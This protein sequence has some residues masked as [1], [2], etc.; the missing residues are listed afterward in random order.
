MRY[1]YVGRDA[2]I[3]AAIQ[4][5]SPPVSAAVL[6]RECLAVRGKRLALVKLLVGPRDGAHP[7]SS[8][9]S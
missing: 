9:I 1:E 3:E 4:L 5:V 8:P 7:G 2:L 6:S